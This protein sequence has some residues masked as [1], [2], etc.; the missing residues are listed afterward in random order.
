MVKPVKF[1]RDS[2]CLAH[3]ELPT[4]FKRDHSLLHMYV[5]AI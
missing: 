5:F 1:T 2:S 4:I 3:N